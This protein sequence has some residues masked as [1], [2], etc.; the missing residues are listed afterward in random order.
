[1][2]TPLYVGSSDLGASWGNSEVRNKGYTKQW[3]LGNYLIPNHV[4]PGMLPKTHADKGTREYISSRSR[5]CWG[6]HSLGKCMSE[7]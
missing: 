1:M 5:R 3:K 2:G 7:E 6:C 4:S